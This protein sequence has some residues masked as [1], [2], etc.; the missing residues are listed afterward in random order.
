MLEMWLLFVYPFSIEYLSFIAFGLS[1]FLEEKKT[2]LALNYLAL[3]TNTYTLFKYN[4]AAGWDSRFN[5]IALAL[6]CIFYTV[7]PL[8]MIQTCLH[9]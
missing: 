6:Y 5:L 2:Q 9:W 1:H 3:K 4:I 7:R 8:K